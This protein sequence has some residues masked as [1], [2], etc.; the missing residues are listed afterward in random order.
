MCRTRIKELSLH[1]VS[2]VLIKKH[3][4]RVTT[5]WGKKED[6]PRNFAK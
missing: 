6:Q 1:T 2:E 3:A 4:L 5:Y